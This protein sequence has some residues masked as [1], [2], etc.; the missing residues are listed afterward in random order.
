MAYHRAVGIPVFPD[1][2][3]RGS[4]DM[5]ILYIT[6]GFPERRM[7]GG[8][9]SSFYRIV[10]LTRAGHEVTVLCLVPRGDTETD[11]A[12]LSE[13]ARI[14]AV[15]DVPDAS[16]PRYLANLFDPLPWPIRRYASRAADRAVRELLDAE[17][18]DLVIANSI[19]AATRLATVRAHTSA[20][21]VLFAPNVQSTIMEL[22]WR[23]LPGPAARL[24]GRIQ[25]RKMVAFERGL[26]PRFDRV[27]VYTETDRS[28]LL[29]LAPDA[30]VEIVPIALDVAALAEGDEAE[31]F[32]MLFIGYLGWAPNLDSLA[33][34]MD[35]IAPRI[36]RLRPGTDL[37]VVGA[38]APPWVGAL[39]D[40]SPYT[41]VHGRVEDATPFFKRARV[42]VVPLRIGSGVRVKIVQAMAVGC[43][44]VTTSKGCE[45]LEVEN[46][47]HLLVADRPDE[48]AEAVVR[49]LESGAER[50]ALGEKARELAAAKHDA[51]ADRPPLVEACERIVREREAR[52][53]A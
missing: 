31:E 37:A 42:L 19:H 53:P 40:E 16:V 20:P 23:H 5:K 11:P 38:G 9:I 35:D 51:L 49:V 15:R 36:R 28:G 13:I 25:W 32:D 52:T 29:D 34:F 7:I 41:R 50:R 3:G 2:S 43:A 46:G 4:R 1:A 10:Q 21:C 30:K 12:E 17:T 14:V 45:G 6:Q 26:A 8:Q 27:F 33:W 24:Y 39:D 22:Y 44:V 48:F 47:T 18:F